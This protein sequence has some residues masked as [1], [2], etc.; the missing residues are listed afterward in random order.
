MRKTIN[1]LGETEWLVMR[2]V[3]N[4]GKQTTGRQ[5]YDETQKFGKRSYQTI[6]TILDRLVD[7]EYLKREKLGP[8]WLYTYIAQ[9]E[10]TVAN[11]VEN[12]IKIVL[13]ENISPVFIH[14]I[15][16]KKKHAKEIE[17]LKKIVSELDDEK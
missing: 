16:N 14:L 9:E 15:K 11:A 2:C 7:K 13:G 6:K 1:G 10:K 8:V 5:I 17:Y 4:I 3:W 12:F